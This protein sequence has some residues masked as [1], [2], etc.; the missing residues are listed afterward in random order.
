MRMDQ[1]GNEPAWAGMD[2]Q[3]PCGVPVVKQSEYWLYAEETAAGWH[4][5]GVRENTENGLDEVR[6]P[7]EVEGRP[8]VSLHLDWTQD[9]EHP[10]YVGQLYIPDCIPGIDG[11]SLRYVLRAEM[12]QTEHPCFMQKENLLLT[13][14]GKKL[15]AALHIHQRYYFVPDG[16]EVIGREAFF[17]RR[18]DRVLL[19]GSVRVIEDGAFQ[20]MPRL[21]SMVVPEGVQRIGKLAFADSGTEVVILP[22][23]LEELGMSAFAGS[24]LLEITLPNRIRALE[25]TFMY[26]TELCLVH[27]NEGLQEIGPYAFQAC[28]NLRR[29][30]LPQSVQRVDDNAFAECETEIIRN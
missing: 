21:R 18:V 14:D 1:R 15:V 7:A 26:C 17:E 2:G 6:I 29:I 27:L 20:D 30:V 28:D 25:Q 8:V 3:H 13:P 10:Q 16:V 24:G 9:P 4:I 11:R 19:P 12:V 5:T 23:S 22:D